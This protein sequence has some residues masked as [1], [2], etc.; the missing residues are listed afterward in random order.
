MQ[1]I[2]KDCGQFAESGKRR[3]EQS[4][5]RRASHHILPPVVAALDPSGVFTALGPRVTVAQDRRDL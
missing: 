3:R 5:N 2:S 1:S 4:S